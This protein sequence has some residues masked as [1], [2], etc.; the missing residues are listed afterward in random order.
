[1]LYSY[2]FLI[3]YVSTTQPIETPTYYLSEDILNVLATTRINNLTITDYPDID[4]LIQD[5]VITNPD[6]TILEQIGE[7]TH[8]WDDNKAFDDDL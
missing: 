8:S 4:E 7:F 6:N 3:F 1:M 5:Q 2:F